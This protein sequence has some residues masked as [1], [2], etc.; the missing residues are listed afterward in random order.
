MRNKSKR[1]L[2]MS[3]ALLAPW[4]GNADD[5]VPLA[6]H[7][8][9]RQARPI[10]GD[11]VALFYGAYVA[12]DTDRRLFIADHGNGRIVSAKLDYHATER[13]PLKQ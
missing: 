11:E 2:V 5:G 4:I 12:T 1:M 9:L 3:M 6:P 7:P 13:V 8:T 10:G